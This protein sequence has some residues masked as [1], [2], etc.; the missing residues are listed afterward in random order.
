MLFEERIK[1][2]EIRFATL[3]AEKILLIQLQMRFLVCSNNI[4][5]DPNVLQS[6]KM[7]RKKCINIITNVQ[8]KRNVL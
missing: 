7:N 5:K 4:G 6:M 2:A 8:L 1:K 3:I